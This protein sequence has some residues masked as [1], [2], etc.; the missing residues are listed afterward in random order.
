MNDKIRFSASLRSVLPD[1]A[2]IYLPEETES[3]NTLG[4]ILL[5]AGEAPHG[6]VILAD[7]QTGGRGRRG[8]SFFS[9][10]G[11]LYLSLIWKK[12]LDAPFTVLCAAAVCRVLRECGALVGIKWVNDLF[13]EGKKVCGI[14][15]ERLTAADGE[16]VILGIGVNCGTEPFPEELTA[17]GNLPPLG[18]SRDQL[19]LCLLGELIRLLEENDDA[20]AKR[21]YAEHMLLYGKRIRWEQNGTKLHGV[22]LGLGKQEELLVRLDSG[23]KQMLISGMITPE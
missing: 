20:E 5:T 18:L 2:Q 6:T 11:G 10:R 22:V 15:C 23:E 1:G 19:A 16:A 13:W 12:R 4:R 21:Y 7:R 8:K 17:A 3:T 9:P 14:L